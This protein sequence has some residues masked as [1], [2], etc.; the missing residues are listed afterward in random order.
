M[1]QSL[2]KT[3]KGSKLCLSSEPSISCSSHIT[4]RMCTLT[5]KAEQ[6]GSDSEDDEDGGDGI[7]LME[8]W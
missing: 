1:I 6:R 5:C 8:A 3:Y 4:T 2:S 7:E